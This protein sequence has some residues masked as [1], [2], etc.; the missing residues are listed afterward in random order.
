MNNSR[1]NLN[2][3]RYVYSSLMQ[4]SL[5]CYL[6]FILRSQTTANP[7]SEAAGFL[8]D[9]S[10]I[11]ALEVFWILN[12]L[13]VPSYYLM[14]IWRWFFYPVHFFVYVFIVIDHQFFAY[15]GTH[16]N[17]SLFGHT[18]T[19]IGELKG[20]L[21]TGIDS[22]FFLNSV[23]A[24]MFFLIA[25]LFLKYLKS[26]L[27]IWMTGFLLLLILF[28]LPLY[29]APSITS[30]HNFNISSSTFVGFFKRGRANPMPGVEPESIYDP[31]KLMGS[32][33][34]RPN[35]VLLIME[36]LRADVVAPYTTSTSTV[37]KPFLNEIA[38]QSLVFEEAYTSVSHT[39]KALVAILCG[40]FP[41]FQMPIIEA[42]PHRLSLTSAAHLLGQVG[43]RSAFFQTALATF[44]NRVGL[45]KNL[46]FEDRFVQEDVKEPGYQKLGYFG[47]DE[48][49]MLKPILNW[50]ASKQDKPF[51]LTVLT[52]LSH[53]PYVMPGQNGLLAHQEEYF[54]AYLKT[55]T[56]TD[57]FAR[58]LFA[59]LSDLR[60]LKNTVIIIVGDHGEAFGEHGLWQHDAVPYQEV[61]RVPL[62]IWGP[63]WL[64]P[65]RRVSGLR[66]HIDI[67]PTLLDI[68]GVSW[69][70][71]LPG[72][73]LISS[74]GHPYV[75]SSGWYTNYCL[76]LRKDH[77]KYIFYY[78]RKPIE[79]FDLKSDPRERQNLA[80]TMPLEGIDSAIR[81]MQ[82]FRLSVDQY[83]AKTR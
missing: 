52:V 8:P 19:R 18:L 67:L 34:Q 4:G 81:E 3:Y 57:E 16:A 46:G 82:R 14:K 51:F 27:L 41:R 30:I 43:Y 40:M 31:P 78:D 53:H 75:V 70:G 35:I 64:G 68:T 62:L 60:L 39:S 5:L 22:K 56:H 29:L 49:A 79:V 50:A 59:G 66:H 48:F 47:M 11:V 10:C 77:L 12:A 54:H 44:E 23:F 36:S 9:L 58:A 6:L 63:S 74:D 25:I 21:G 61:T 42:K 45:L 72:K 26:R 24:M 71:R 76:S 2:R 80:S 73:S 1:R 55:V 7:I 28:V 33:K 69:S 83:Y 32:A 13:F 37:H 38:Q 17:V 15:T 20:I 65:P